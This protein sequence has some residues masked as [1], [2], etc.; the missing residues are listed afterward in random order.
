LNSGPALNR[1]LA[2]AHRAVGIT[3][4]VFWLLQAVTGMLLVFRW[5]LEDT[6]LAGPRA[7]ADA[8]G[9]GAAI[10]EIV[11]AGGRPIDL[12]ASS[13]AATR[14]DIYYTDTDGA[15]RVMRVDGSGRTL[16]DAADAGLIGSGAFWDTLT[17]V[18]TGLLGGEAGRWVV[19]AS[20]AILLCN[21]AVG[22]RIAWPRAGEW[23][24]AL[25]GRIPGGQAAR[26]RAWH[27]R[28]GLWL[29]ALVLPF[30]AA[31]VLLCFEDELRTSLAASVPEPPIH[32]GRSPGIMPAEA[33][34][35]AAERD[36]AARLSA[37]ILPGDAE[38]WY[39]VRQLRAGDLP[40][41]WGT[42]TLFIA[43]S[44]GQVLGE[45][46]AARAPATRAL[47]DAIYP[48]HT[49]Q[50]AGTAGRLLVLLQG[51]WLATMILLGIRMW[52]GRRW[53]SD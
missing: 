1:G 36:P 49:G 45:H 15:P 21:L 48:F 29:G 8:E 46:S 39:R 52:R 12:W 44:D 23:G 53:H 13:Q 19:A 27:R 3:M 18:H 16:R 14:F 47:V 42:S 10:E 35:I 25:R 34:A 24:R 50:A 37:M 38:P 40:R 31:G 26:I 17:L 32:E 2:R 6:L 22:L 43:S 51:A 41:N 4:A 30:V 9:L 20:G 11:R 5:E 33:L 7:S 28:F